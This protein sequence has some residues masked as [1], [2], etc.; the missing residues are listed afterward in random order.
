MRPAH[1]ACLLFLLLAGGVPAGGPTVPLAAEIAGCEDWLAGPVCT[2][3]A[4]PLKLWIAGARGLELRLD[5]RRVALEPAPRD[6]GLLIEL[7]APA[8]ARSL[9]ILTADGRLELSLA[10]SQRPAWYPELATAMNEGRLDEAK[11]LLE[12]RRGLAFPANAYKLGLLARVAYNQSDRAEAA[13]LGRRAADL[14]IEGG[15]AGAAIRE[16]TFVGHQLHQDGERVPLREILLRTRTTFE[17]LASDQILPVRPAFYLD[18]LEAT[19]FAGGGDL[20]SALAALDNLDALGRHG[21]LSAREILQKDEQRALVL[22]ELGRFAEAAALL[23]GLLGTWQTLDFWRAEL[24]T[25]RG[26]IALLSADAGKSEGDPLPYFAEAW[27]YH[28]D[29]QDDEKRFNARLNL[30]AA[31]LQAGHPAAA[32]AH[33][34][35]AAAF[36]AGASVP[37]KFM[38]L[39]LEARLLLLDGRAEDARRGFQE[40]DGQATRFR[41]PGLR[42]QA[43]LGQAQALD[44]L[45]RGREAVEALERADALADGELLQIPVDQGRETFLARRDQATR[46]HLKLLLDQGQ[47]DKAWTVLWQRLRQAHRMLQRYEALAA[48]GESQR[49]QLDDAISRFRRTHAVIEQETVEQARLPVDQLARHQTRLA[50]HHADLDHLRDAILEMLPFGPPPPPGVY[51]ASEGDL[52]L[53]FFPLDR[54]WLALARDGR[55]ALARRLPPRPPEEPPEAL[56]AA[57]LGLFRGEIDT[58]RRLEVA[59]WGELAAVDFQGLESAKTVVYAVPAGRRR[60]ALEAPTSALLVEAPGLTFPAQEIAF[61]R[62]TLENRLPGLRIELPDPG[63]ATP[64]AIWPRIEVAD[65]L[66]F[67]GHSLFAGHGGFE[68]RLLLKGGDLRVGDLFTLRRVPR[69]VI[70][71]SCEGGLDR[72]PRSGDKALGLAQAFILAGADQVL[73]ASRPV[74]DAKAARLMREIYLR[75]P[76]AGREID[77]AALLREARLFLS[78]TD[79]DPTWEAF[80]VFEP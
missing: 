69:R 62:T 71:S 34:Q 21:L 46:L 2:L 57:L 77:L 58:A 59:P 9:E 39:E 37:Q 26:W 23:D 41:Q 8:A 33:L 43:L 79:P 47:L 56:A 49:R 25:N 74:D 61:A 28:Q 6:G 20:R 60:G 80:R 4:D 7:A 40:L 5:G 24:A 42:W 19:V 38:A 70:L 12:E 65:F 17:E 55:R 66:H 78:Q 16:L 48:L 52:A 31:E 50:G 67:A 68:S 51:E 18:M 76:P 22:G 27:R 36:Q 3:G 44:A 72:D 64:F 45:G 54:S 75:W 63:K 13:N 32:R 53:A 11:R 30:A 29:L 10:P 35:A 15:Y 1:L 73:A 14:W